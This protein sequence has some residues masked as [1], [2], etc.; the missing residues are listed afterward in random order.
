MGFRKCSVLV[1]GESKELLGVLICLLEAGHQ[2]YVLENEM[3]IATLI[4]G[5]FSSKEKETLL[6]RNLKKVNHLAE[7]SRVELAIALTAENRDAKK[8]LIHELEKAVPADAL[9]AINSE[10]IPLQAIRD[11]ARFPQRIIALNWTEPAHTTF[12]LEIVSDKNT[13]AHLVGDLL[14]VAQKEWQ[15]DP[16]VLTNGLGI[17]S[18]MM[19]ALLREAFGLIEKGY[20]GVEDIDRACRNDAGYYLPFSGHFRYMDLMGTYLYGIVMKE[21]NPELSKESHIPVFFT[22]L[23]QQGAKGMENN[24]GFYTYTEE[25]KQQFKLSFKKF[26]H[27]MKCLISQYSPDF[28]EISASEK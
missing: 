11:A 16:Y 26:S 9:I 4:E 20:V 17:R 10:S 8:A 27:E 23:I 2:V 12:F 1:V 5:C 15:K 14:E 13:S 28:L 7:I 25:E 22:D 3:D 6:L 21:L 19:A 18:R 24:K